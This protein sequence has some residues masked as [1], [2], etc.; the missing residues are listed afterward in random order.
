MVTLSECSWM[1]IVVSR[2]WFYVFLCE[3]FG[4]ADWREERPCSCSLTAV[5]FDSSFDKRRVI[6]RLR[7]KAPYALFLFAE[8]NVKHEMQ[9]GQ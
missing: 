3:S 2:A 9:C 7:G 5:I 1:N 8:S 4:Y 6:D